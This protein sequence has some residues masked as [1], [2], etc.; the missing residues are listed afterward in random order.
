MNNDDQMFPG[1]GAAGNQSYL[2][3]AISLTET[4]RDAGDRN[5]GKRA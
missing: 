5:Q 2:T 3:P 4:F 1:D